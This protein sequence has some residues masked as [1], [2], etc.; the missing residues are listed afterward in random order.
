MVSEGKSKM[1]LVTKIKTIGAST[2]QLWSW[3]DGQKKATTYFHGE[4]SSVGE[5]VES[6]AH[7]K[8]E[9]DIVAE[10]GEY[11]P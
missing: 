7:R 4:F 8:S 10:L 1:T 5:I 3:I 6:I 2:I 11:R 9:L